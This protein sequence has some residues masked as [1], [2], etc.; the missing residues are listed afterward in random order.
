MPLSEFDAIA[1]QF[2]AIWGRHYELEADAVTSNLIIWANTGVV[3]INPDVLES[4]SDDQQ[5]ALR[6]AAV[7]ALPSMIDVDH[8]RGGCCSGKRCATPG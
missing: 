7:D 5:A 3:V 4:L 1:M 6:T 2:G 8:R